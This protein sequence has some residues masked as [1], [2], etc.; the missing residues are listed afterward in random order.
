[1]HT[2]S[3]NAH[4]VPSVALLS[5]QL[6]TA[7]DTLLTSWEFSF[8]AHIGLYVCWFKGVFTLVVWYFLIWTKTGNYKFRSYHEKNVL[9]QWRSHCPF[10]IRRKTEKFTA[11]LDWLFLIVFQFGQFGSRVRH[12]FQQNP[13][14]L[15]GGT[16]LQVVTFTHRSEPH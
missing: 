13:V 3:L 11:W 15:F 16:K 6:I 12:T 5:I 1:M 7:F 9:L 10:N 8:R 4:S 2:V 14:C